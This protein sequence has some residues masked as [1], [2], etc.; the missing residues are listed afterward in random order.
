MNSPV[1]S[2]SKDVINV[3]YWI[4]MVCW[5]LLVF[6]LGNKPVH[7][8]E[9]NFLAMTQGEFWRPHLIQINWEG[10]EQSA[11]DVLSNPP[12]MVWFLWPVKDLSVVWMRAWVLPWSFLGLWGVWKC[13][14]HIG[15]SQQ[16]LWLMLCSPIFVLSH[17]SLMP[18]MPLFACIVMGWQGVLSRQN[19][20]LWAFVLGMSALFRYSG[21]TMIPL[22]TAW[23]FLNKPPKGWRLII[24][25]SIPTLLLCVHDIWAYGE[26]HFLHMIA[27]QQEQ[28]SWTAVAHK[29]CALSSMLV[30]GCGVV[31]G[32]DKSHKAVLKILVPCI[33]IT[34]TISYGFDLEMSLLAWVSIPIGF[35]TVVSFVREA[36]GANRYWVLCWLVGGLIFLLSLRFAATRYWLPF[37][38]PYWLWM[39]ESKWL[40][41]W[42]LVMGIVSIH[43]AWDDAQLAKAQHQLAHQVVQICDTQYG[44]T[45]GYFSGHWGWQYALEAS[46]WESVEDDSKIPNSVCFSLS[47]SSWPQ[48]ISNDCFESFMSLQYPYDSFGL[49]IRVHTADGIANYHSYM[50]SSKPPIRTMTPFGWGVD[51]WDQVEFRRSCRR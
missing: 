25:V 24:A 41:Y 46:G 33:V 51:D 28:H 15:G 22:L 44:E 13:I 30:L 49:P 16:R 21:L 29:L 23:V 7:L 35:F 50:I 10:V 26:W 40:K 43:L 8:D 39:H 3:R 38:G 17:N 47:K 5:I 1:D 20:T 19:Q 37:V 12:G 42:T 2:D 9:A 11:F 32:F 34:A 27:F 4:A 36:I 6:G 18:E 45:T 14:T 48:E 31:P